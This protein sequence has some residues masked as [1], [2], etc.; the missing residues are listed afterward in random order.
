MSTKTDDYSEFTD[1]ELAALAKPVIDRLLA[2]P[3]TVR[4]RARADLAKE[5]SRL[6]DKAIWDAISKPVLG[7]QD[8][9]VIRVNCGC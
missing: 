8:Y 3:P 5:M 4:S 7:A 6:V 1:D 9:G 2:D